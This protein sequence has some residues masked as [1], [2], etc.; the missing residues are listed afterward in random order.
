MLIPQAELGKEI[1][2]EK[3]NSDGLMAGRNKFKRK[4]LVRRGWTSTKA[5]ARPSDSRS[6]INS[7]IPIGWQ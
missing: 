3:E 2:C 4:R 6:S 5:R 1:P 7:T